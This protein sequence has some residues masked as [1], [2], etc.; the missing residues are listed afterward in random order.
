MAF[1]YYSLDR[2]FLRNDVTIDDCD[3]VQ[4]SPYWTDDNDYTN[5]LDIYKKASYYIS[6]RLRRHGYS[7]VN[8]Y[9]VNNSDRSYVDPSTMGDIFFDA[10]MHMKNCK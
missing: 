4:R 3:P 2:Y 5:Y 1:Y 9:I 6:A 10:F 7:I 8:D